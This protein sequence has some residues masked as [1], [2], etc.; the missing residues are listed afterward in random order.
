MT[1]ILSQNTLSEI[2]FS[3]HIWQ[4]AL[5]EVC[6]VISFISCTWISGEYH[7]IFHVHFY[8]PHSPYFIH[9]HFTISNS[10]VHN[11]QSCDSVMQY[12]KWQQEKYFRVGVRFSTT[13][14]QLLFAISS[15]WLRVLQVTRLLKSVSIHVPVSFG[16]AD[17]FTD[18][19]KN[20]KLNSLYVI[21]T[22]FKTQMA[23]R[24]V[25]YHSE[26]CCGS[27]YLL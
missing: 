25:T 21:S 20:H 5:M 26:L 7:M 17:T 12:E 15:D 24:Q 9:N 6:F 19:L 8:Q 14:W 23:L 13:F 2:A 1:G 22:D 3:I 10:I 16:S 27:E 11:R 18:L 4:P